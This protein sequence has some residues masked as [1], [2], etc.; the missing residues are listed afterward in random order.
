M[1]PHIVG[2]IEHGPHFIALDNVWG[3]YADRGNPRKAG[4]WVKTK[5]LDTGKIVKL[6]CEG[7]SSRDRLLISAA[8]TFNQVVEGVLYREQTNQN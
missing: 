6:F 2:Y 3:V 7:L 5:N 1:T 4:Y 8:S